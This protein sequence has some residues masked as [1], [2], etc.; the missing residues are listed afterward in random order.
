MTK[1]VKIPQFLLNRRSDPHARIILEKWLKKTGRTMLDIMPWSLIS[2]GFEDGTFSD[3]GIGDG[4]GDGGD[5]YG[6]GGG[7]G[8]SSAGGDGSL[9]DGSYGEGG[10]I[11]QDTQIANLKKEEVNMTPGLKL[12]S[13]GGGGFYPYIM[14]GWWKQVD[15][16]EW[17]CYNA[18]II[19]RQGGEVA[20]TT[21][22]AHGPQEAKGRNKETVLLPMAEA[23][24]EVHRLMIR[25]CLKCDETSWATACPKP[26]NWTPVDLEDSVD[27]DGITAID[28]MEVLG[29]REVA[30]AIEKDEQERNEYARLKAKFESH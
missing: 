15:G 17:E 29:L 16:D 9:G 13:I 28:A 11:G 14:V 25:R 20:L 30:Q 12:V 19:K 2:C 22:A 10:P 6:D 7:D 3:D 26:E 18:R 4:G 23:P 21:L 8:D 1:R 24:E 5:G 27:G